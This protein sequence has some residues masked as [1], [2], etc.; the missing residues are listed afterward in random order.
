MNGD[1]ERGWLVLTRARMGRR[2]GR[3][4]RVAGHEELVRRVLEISLGLVRVAKRYEDGERWELGG[5]AI[6]GQRW[7][8]RR[9]ESDVR[10]E[11]VRRMGG[12]V[13]VVG[14]LIAD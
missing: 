8:T 6:L 12:C 14:M 5:R 13:W 2:R 11:V 3:G 10:T 4:W 1:M 9:R 7:R